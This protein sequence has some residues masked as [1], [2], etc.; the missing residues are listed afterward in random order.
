MG[1]KG[2]QI[3]FLVAMTMLDATVAFVGCRLLGLRR[4]LVMSAS[5]DCD[6]HF[7]MNSG[8]RKVLW[9]GAGL[10]PAVAAGN[11]KEAWAQRSFDEVRCCVGMVGG[12]FYT[13]DI[14]G[15]SL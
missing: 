3:I 7:H 4:D 6:S 15:E 5:C 10:L 8:R 2:W 12:L 1:K 14:T 11:P 13:F 9:L